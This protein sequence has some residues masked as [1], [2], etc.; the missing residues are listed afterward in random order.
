LL[1]NTL[2]L[3]LAPF[4][5][6]SWPLLVMSPSNAPLMRAVE[7]VVVLL[8]LRLLLARFVERFVDFRLVAFRF[9]GLFFAL[10]FAV[11]FFVALRL[12]LFVVAMN[13]LLAVVRGDKGRAAS[14]TPGSASILIAAI[15]VRDGSHRPNLSGK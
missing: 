3:Q 15:R 12:V 4:A 9:A 5:M 13:Q 2:P 6:C 8:N 11:D 7:P 10:R 1:A 14:K